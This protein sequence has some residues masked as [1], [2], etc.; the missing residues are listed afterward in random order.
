M[1]YNTNTLLPL[2]VKEYGSQVT[3]SESPSFEAAP[4]QKSATSAMN[5]KRTRM[6]K[7]AA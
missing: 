1:T 2:T 3:T 6:A 4:A 7:E 5:M